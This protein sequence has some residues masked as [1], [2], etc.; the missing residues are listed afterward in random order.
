MVVT[1][2]KLNQTRKKNI[3]HDSPPGE[4]EST[5]LAMLAHQLST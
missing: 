5:I 4:T 1:A 2:E 3:A